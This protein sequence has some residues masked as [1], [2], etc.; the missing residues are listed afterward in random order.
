[1]PSQ[2]TP[3]E[4]AVWMTTY[5]GPFTTDPTT[6]E[7]IQTTRRGFVEL[8]L[9]DVR[10]LAIP[11]DASKEKSR[12]AKAALPCYSLT[13]SRGDKRG[14]D[15]LEG[16][17]AISLDLDDP[18]L[19]VG[20]DTAVENLPY[21]CVVLTSSRHTAEAPRL[22]AHVWTSRPVDA[23]EYSACWE[24]LRDLA[25]RRGMGVG[26][27]AK[28][29]A[30]IWFAPATVIGSTFELRE[31]AG[32]D[33]DVD[34][35]LA[36]MAKKAKPGKQ[37]GKRAQ[38]TLVHGSRS[39]E[40]ERCRAYL[41]KKPPAVDGE[42]GSGITFNVAATIVEWVADV[43]QHEGLMREY[44]D[45]CL[46]P[47]SD[48][49]QKH[50]L[51]SAY[52]STSYQGPPS[53]ERASTPPPPVVDDDA[54]P[55][56]VEHNGQPVKTAGNVA[57][58]MAVFPGGCPRFDSL[59]NRVIWPDGQEHSD[60]RDAEVQQW[61][62]AQPVTHRVLVGI[63]GVHAGIKLAASKREFHPVAEYLSSLTWDDV[64]RIDAFAE[65]YLRATPR[66]LNAAYMRCFFVGAVARA[67]RPGCQFDTT[68]VLEG[69]Q[70]ARKTSALRVLGGP[71]YRSSHIDV[72]K[73][74]DCYQALEGAWIYELSEIDAYT[75]ANEQGQLKSFLSADA[76]TYRP[77]YGRNSIRRLRGVAFV[78][79]TNQSAYL[80]D[81]TGGRR[82]HPVACGDVDLASLVRDRDQL[83][84]EARAR[85]D[86]GE[87]WWLDA[88][89]E[90]QA[91]ED[92]EDRREA[93]AWDDVLPTLLRD[94]VSV[95]SYACLTLIGVEPVRQDRQATQRVGAALRRIG[96]SRHRITRS[97]NQAWE[98][99]RPN[100]G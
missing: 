73:R 53:R 87:S 94:H 93:D 68:M 38:L 51:K 24:Y 98:Y 18:S 69:K 100:S 86:A 57:L 76:D 30:R 33:L 1:M 10:Q 12:A 75:G 49:E 66:E 41:A 84:A 35:V 25:L 47:W 71:W 26:R 17:Y 96:W 11:A 54:L 21:A 43:S 55:D 4:R 23:K 34:A 8:L 5:P 83:W 36:E 52:A 48:A 80:R 82:I 56:L 72:R 67:M 77:S 85:F 32:P 2:D 45:R 65:T 88:G 50:K 97:G 64:P 16:C 91:A 79:T 92:V 62:A 99:R 81:D 3:A 15:F 29:A 13:T 46:P 90:A 74:P 37:A 27:E 6:H 40:V 28:E 20:I 22:R 59:L 61:L 60:H 89:M 7:R 14:L 19:P 78:G 95:T 58:M 9:S 42:G 31:G 63:D 39:S 44:S 70:G